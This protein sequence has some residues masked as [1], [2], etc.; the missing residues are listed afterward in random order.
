[1]LPRKVINLHHENRLKNEGNITNALKKIDT[2]KNLD[3]L[4]QRRFSYIEKNIKGLV[5]ILELGCGAG[6]SKKYCHK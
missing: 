3:F 6:H 5:D 2:N 1:M 4:L